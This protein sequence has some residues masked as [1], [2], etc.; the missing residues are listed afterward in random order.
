MT[1]GHTDDRKQIE[2]FKAVVTE[3]QVVETFLSTVTDQ[4]VTAIQNQLASLHL[5]EA[6][7]IGS[8]NPKK[9]KIVIADNS[10]N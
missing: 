2:E 3:V 5:K 4:K 8:F 9:G 1:N 7:V 10:W 6:P